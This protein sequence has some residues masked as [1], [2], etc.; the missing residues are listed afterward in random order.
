MGLSDLCVEE[1]L[2]SLPLFS[3]VFLQLGTVNEVSG[4]YVDALII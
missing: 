2:S 4:A 1:G 3:F